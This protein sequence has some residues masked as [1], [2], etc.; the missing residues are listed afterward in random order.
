MRK[1]SI[2]MSAL[3]T[4]IIKFRQKINKLICFTQNNLRIL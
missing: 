1:L 3:I 4:N 2:Y